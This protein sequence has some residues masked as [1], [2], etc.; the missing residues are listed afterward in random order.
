MTSIRKTRKAWKRKNGVKLISFYFEH[1][2]RAM[3]FTPTMRKNC[4]HSITELF[5]K[6]LIKKKRCTLTKTA[7]GNSPSAT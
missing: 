6:E 4:R 2:N 5:R 7:G 3:C 1:K